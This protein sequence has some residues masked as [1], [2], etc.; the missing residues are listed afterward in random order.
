MDL[1]LQQITTNYTIHIPEGWI[2]W[3]LFFGWTVLLTVFVYRFYQKERIQERNPAI[4]FFYIFL[5]IICSLL[6]CFRAFP[7]KFQFFPTSMPENGDFFLLLF[8]AIPW[9][10]AAAFGKPILSIV[11]ALSGSI[12]FTGFYGHTVFTILLFS[13]IGFFF[14]VFMRTKNQLIEPYQQH[15]IILISL[16]I[17]AA[18]PLFY[19]EQFASVKGS[20]ALRIDASFHDGWI[21]YLSRISELLLAGIFAEV[22]VQKKAVKKGRISEIHAAHI[23]SKQKKAIHLISLFYLTLLIVT[24]IWNTSRATVLDTYREDMNARLEHISVSLT[25]PFTSNA[26]RIDQ[27]SKSTLL[28]GTTSEMNALMKTLF[29]PI[30]NVDEFYLFDNHGSLVYAY[31]SISEE[32]MIVSDQEILVYQEVLT[33]KTILGSFSRGE[34]NSVFMSILYPIIDNEDTVQR[35]ILARI[36]VTKNPAFFAFSTLVSDYEKNGM[37]LEFLNTQLDIHLPWK[38]KGDGEKDQ[39]VAVATTYVPM[40]LD[41][42]GIQLALEKNVFLT[43][44]FDQIYP[45]FLLSLTGII[46]I[47]G[48]YFYRWMKLEE[49][50]THLTERFSASSNTDG[51]SIR[52]NS[53]P[54]SV[55][56]LLEVLKQIFQKLEVRHQKTET[57]LNLWKNYN[58][59]ESFK[60]IL[61]EALANFTGPDSIYVRMFIENRIGK[62]I[63]Q[64]FTY[65][66]VENIDDFSYLDE[67]ILLLGKEQ[68]QLVVGNTSRFHQLTRALGKPFPQAFILKKIPMDQARGALLFTSYRTEQDFSQDF[69]DDFL[70]KTGEFRR[71]FG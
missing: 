24:V 22:I 14:N 23:S 48:F 36:D 26:I 38:E 54:D 3:L 27:L 16:V 18:F 64:I 61:E 60:T 28:T 49:S 50:L 30:Q 13:T 17:V 68:D 69:M 20:I 58:D 37:H 47:S 66:E 52:M 51:S 55:V 15:P 43:T 19:I 39:F 44:F 53:Y 5:S 57:F 35:I 6:F 56:N 34:K 9:I 10:A 29:L 8:Q 1:L 63:P 25:T 62:E 11:L 33:E 67:Q 32:E 7:I 41:G 45:F 40:S 31:P 59:S 42:W 46:S 65:A 70:E 2:E 21:F 71:V 12:M 4:W